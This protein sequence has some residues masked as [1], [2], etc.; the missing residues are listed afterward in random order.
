MIKSKRN[1]IAAF[2]GGGVGA[3]VAVL[4]QL[5]AFAISGPGLA[6]IAKKIRHL[7]ECLYRIITKDITVYRRARSLWWQRLNLLIHVFRMCRELLTDR[8]KRVRGN[9]KAIL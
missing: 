7:T 5:K 6:S 9:D 1:M 3:V 8:L 4:L 2:I